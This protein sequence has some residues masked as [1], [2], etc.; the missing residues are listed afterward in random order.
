MNRIREVLIGEGLD[1]TELAERLGKGFN[2]A[3]LYA[4]YR[5]CPPCL[6]C[7]GNA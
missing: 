5:V 6:I 4:N 1:K 3:N 2:M 7:V